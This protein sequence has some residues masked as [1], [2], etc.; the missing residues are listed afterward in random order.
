MY[1][2]ISHV[3]PFPF[4]RNTYLP[5]DVPLLAV[6]NWFLA[7]LFSVSDFGALEAQ[8]KG[9]GR[10]GEGRIGV[11][12]IIGLGWVGLEWNGMEILYVTRETFA[13]NRK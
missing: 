9:K 5:D 1:A 10:E 6:W 2:S 8:R 12:N 7:P 11:P 4:T 13:Q 3:P